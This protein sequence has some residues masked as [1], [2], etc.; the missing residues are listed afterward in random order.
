M[1]KILAVFE[2]EVEGVRVGVN[3]NEINGLKETAETPPG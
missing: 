2:G 1:G 3:P